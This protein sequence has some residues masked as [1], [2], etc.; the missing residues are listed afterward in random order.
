MSDY[1]KAVLRDAVARNQFNDEE[2]ESGYA[3]RYTSQY[4]YWVKIEDPELLSYTP[5]RRWNIK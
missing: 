5:I 1:E 2:K 3:Y 4:Q